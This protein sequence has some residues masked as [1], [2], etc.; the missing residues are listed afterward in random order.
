MLAP[1]QAEV[2][3]FLIRNVIDP[4]HYVQENMALNMFARP[5][6]P[7]QGAPAMPENALSA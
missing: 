6:G 2:A 1:V 4:D 5:G 7:P 3:L